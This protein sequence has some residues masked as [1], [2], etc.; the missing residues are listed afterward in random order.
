MSAAVLLV[1]P[2]ACPATIPFTPPFVMIPVLVLVPGS[3]G[4]VLRP[5]INPAPVR[6]LSVALPP[7]ASVSLVVLVPPVLPVS[8]VV[9]VDLVFPVSLLIPV[10][11]DILPSSIIV[12][13]G[14]SSLRFLMIQH[15]A[16]ATPRP[17]TPPTPWSTQLGVVP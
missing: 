5:P 4:P 13:V 3:R 10:A 7:L 11:P 17:T 2:I 12:P 6:E 8:L 1:I 9:L 16:I 15:H 14:V